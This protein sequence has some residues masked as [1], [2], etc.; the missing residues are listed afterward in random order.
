VL[1]AAGFALF[2]SCFG[3]FFSRLLRC[4]PLAMSSSALCSRPNR[5]LGSAEGSAIAIA[6]E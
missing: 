4:C 5:A 1:G 2:L 3:F 6:C